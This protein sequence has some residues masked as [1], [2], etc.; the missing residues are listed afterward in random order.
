MPGSE[1][2][3]GT[4]TDADINRL[5]HAI[6][7][8]FSRQMEAI[9]YDVSTPESRASI[10][11]DHDFVRDLRKGTSKAK[12]TALAMLTVAIFGAVGK[13][14]VDGFIHAITLGVKGHGGP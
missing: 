8:S 4:L 1:H 14:M 13:W 9:G 7:Q 12:M 11:A 3:A 6:D 5:L 2:K 10:H